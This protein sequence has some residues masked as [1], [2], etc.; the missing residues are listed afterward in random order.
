M[1]ATRD[2]NG[3]REDAVDELLAFLTEEERAQV[4]RDLLR[5]AP[6][7]K[8]APIAREWRR[9]IPLVFPRACTAPFADRHVEFWNWIDA[10]DEDS[11]PRPFTAFWPRGGG[12]SSSVELGIA[13]LGCRGKRKYVL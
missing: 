12:K 1:I 2:A 10:I 7:P 8:G 4:D 11:A 6:R 5:L 9:R 3:I 13:D